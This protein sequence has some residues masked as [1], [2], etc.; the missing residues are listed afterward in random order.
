MQRGGNNEMGRGIRQAQINCSG[1]GCELW[2]PIVNL[3]RTQAEFDE[4]VNS[5]K[6]N[7]LCARC[8]ADAERG[9]QFPSEV[10]SPGQIER[11]RPPT[12]YIPHDGDSSE[13]K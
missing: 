13:A 1:C 11:N 7:V 3:G 8:T 2:I 12:P 6:D 9:K 10:K 5:A 4:L